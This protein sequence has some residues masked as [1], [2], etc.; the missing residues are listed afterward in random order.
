MPGD[1]VRRMIP[2][3]DT[4]RGY[5][6]DIFVKADVKIVGTKLVIKNISAD[7][8]KPLIT[9]PRDNAVCLDSWVGSTKT[10][11]EK[12]VLMYEIKITEKMFCWLNI[13]CIFSSSCGSILELRPDTEYCPLKDTET[14]T[15]NGFFAGT[16]FYPGQ[17]LVGP[18][19]ALDSAKWIKTSNEMRTSRKHKTVD[20]KVNIIFIV[21]YN[22]I[23]INNKKFYS[24]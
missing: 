4:Q 3:K 8:F 21:Y 6:R 2:G 17:V 22:S 5:C 1:V 12:L 7:R 16:L 11:H 20:R 19:S 15:R 13:V 14:K 23:N 18:V 9:M 10:V 24:L